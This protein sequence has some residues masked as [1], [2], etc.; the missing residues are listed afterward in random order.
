MC[1]LD[2]RRTRPLLVE[3]SRAAANR[4]PSKDEL[5]EAFHRS[6]RDETPLSDAA[7]QLAELHRRRQEHPH[8]RA[9]IDS[10][11]GELVTAV[12]CWVATHTPPPHPQARAHTET[13]GTLIDRMAAA[14]ATAFHVL[15]TCDPGSDTVHAAWTRLAELENAYS[16]LTDDVARG[17]RRLPHT[18]CDTHERNPA[19]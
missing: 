6:D 19:Q 15:M 17:W 10:L 18:Q 16:D 7:T 4:F 9:E 11:R 14:A 8:R 2:E 13:V 12:D 5:L 3:G 1:L